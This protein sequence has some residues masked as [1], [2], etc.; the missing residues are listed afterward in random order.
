MSIIYLVRHGESEANAGKVTQN[1]K[2]IPLTELGHEQAAKVPANLPTHIDRIFYSSFYRTKQTAEPT[3]K[4]HP[5]A[6]IE[7]WADIHEFDY[8]RP[9]AYIG[10]TILE[11][12]VEATE[13]WE[14]GDPYYQIDPRVE[15]FAQMIDRI[16]RVWQALEENYKG[17]DEIVV[18]FT[19]ALFLKAFFQVK[20]Q[21]NDSVKQL[22][23]TFFECPVIQN[24]EIFKVEM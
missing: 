22:M 4:V 17:K 13:Y 5:E 15:S 7:L 14:K 8:L 18:L 20:N 24:C 2:D 9:E 12:R 21:P 1:S 6:K 10:T 11:R 23:N 16:H 3:I 19:H